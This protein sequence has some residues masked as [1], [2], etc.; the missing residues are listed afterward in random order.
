MIILVLS[1]HLSKLIIR[2]IIKIM[3]TNSNSE[4]LFLIDGSS[5][6]YRAYYSMKP[7]HAPDGQTTQAVY[8]FCRMLKKII[9]RFTPENMVLVWDSR[10]KTKRHE[11]YENYKSTRQAP[12]SDLGSQKQL[13]KEFADLIKLAQVEQSGIEADDLIYSLA[14]EF[15]PTHKIVVITSDKDLYQLLDETVSIFDPFKD[16][17]ITE[18]EHE[19]ILEF[20]IA[21][22]PFYFALLGDTSDN[23]PGVKGIGKKGA[24]DLVKEFDSLDDLYSR[25]EKVKKASTQNALSENRENAFL[26]LTLFL[27][28]YVPTNLAENSVKFDFR[29]WEQANHFFEKLNFKTLL[30]DA[31]KKRSKNE[32]STKIPFS[33]KRGYTF[34]TIAT[35]QDLDALAAYLKDK[36]TFATD[37]ETTS[38]NTLDNELVGISF[39]AEKGISFYV[40]VA[41]KNETTLLSK[42]KIFSV[43]KPILESIEYTKILHNAKFDALVLYNAGINLKGI[44]FDTIIAASLV[45]K[46]GQRINLAQLSYD[47]LNDEM[48]EYDEVVKLNKYQDFSFTPIALATQYAAADAHQTFSLKEIFETKLIENNLFNLFNNIEMPLMNVLIDVEKNGI[49]L[50]TS[51]LISLEESIDEELGSIEEKIKTLLD[52][53]EGI[54]LNSPKQVEELLFVKLNLPRQKKSSKRTGYS[55]DQEVLTTLS[56]LH[57]VPGL[58]LKYRELYKLK[59]TY[60]GGLPK[61]V[62]SKDK[63]IHTS[64]NQTRTSTGRLASSEPNL[65]NIPADNSIYAQKLRGAFKADNGNVFISADYSQIE[66]RVLA[67]LSKDENL[68]KSFMQ[69]L[70]IH[71]IT[72]AKI[73]EIDLDKITYDQ[74]QVGKRINFSILYGLTPYGL[75]KE[76]HIPFGDAKKYIEKYFAQ[77]P[78]VQK[79]MEKI[80]QETTEKGYVETLWGRRRYISEI[81]ERNKGLYEFAKR[82]AINT[83]AQGTAA[84]IMKN[85]MIQLNREIPE[86]KIILQIHD[87]L[88][89]S[90]PENRAQELEIKIRNILENVTK[91]NIPLKVTTRTGKTWQEASK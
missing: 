50:E 16:A 53:T 71:A 45:A 81:Y 22:L 5:F 85:G 31:Q 14:K 72:A 84:E 54:N 78:E 23:I 17:I 36:K 26:S 48:L 21:K 7:L 40:P 13:I 63:K 62:N 75:S 2:A 90:V 87:E 73:F 68:A 58:I 19:K 6:L 91:W 57:P 47:Y 77:Y 82:A 38:L 30:K 15:S 86:A 43:L 37:T 83:V 29:N 66:L 28:I 59:S 64:L 1:S 44:I 67:H 60:I 88:L 55:T 11:L 32:I 3:K 35:E 56:Y 34:K 76:L 8:G 24:S 79:W 70:D 41:H 42:D 20:P 25:I 49:Y 69:D 89:I 52:Q 74:R 33:V 65:Q 61:Y 9:D 27:L 18:E 51:E 46:E 39:C 80:V 12:P 4:T 10:G